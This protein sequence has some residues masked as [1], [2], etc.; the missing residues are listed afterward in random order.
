M[1]SA[2]SRMSTRSSSNLMSLRPRKSSNRPG[3]ATGK[4][5]CGSCAVV[6]LPKGPLR[7][8]LRVKVTCPST[9]CTDPRPA[10]RVRGWERASTR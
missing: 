9:C 1:R 3:V 10:S 6:L 7:P 8:G 2:S 5:P 4:L